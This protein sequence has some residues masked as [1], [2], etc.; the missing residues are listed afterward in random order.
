MKKSLIS[1]SGA[2]SLFFLSLFFVFGISDLKAEAN[3]YNYT[4]NF[5]NTAYKDSAGTTAI[6]N[7]T[8]GN[9]TLPTESKNQRMPSIDF[10]SDKELLVSWVGPMISGNVYAQKLDKNGNKIWANDVKV[11]PQSNEQHTVGEKPVIV[12]EPVA[13]KDQMNIFWQ[14]S[15]DHKLTFQTINSFGNVRLPVYGIQEMK[16]SSSSAVSSIDAA[17]FSNNAYTP[18]Y[19]VWVDNRNKN[20]GDIYL[21]KIK[22]G[23]SYPEYQWS[24]DVKVNS[25]QDGFQKSP[26]VAVDSKGDVYVVWSS[27]RKGGSVVSPTD[28]GIFMQK[29]SSSGV[30]LWSSD[31]VVSQ[32]GSSPSIDVDLSS[33]TPAVYVSWQDITSSSYNSRKYDVF[34]Q[35]FDLN[36]NIAWPNSYRIE[37]GL[38]SSPSPIV[39]VNQRSN[40]NGQPVHVAW[41]NASEKRIK[42]QGYRQDV[43]GEVICQYGSNC[44]GTSYG[45]I[46]SP[47]LSSGFKGEFDFLRG[48][49]ASR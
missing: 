37:S 47:I 44:V 30:R 16:L 33:D 13:Y 27:G 14:D 38:T 4:E 31:I 3:T 1:K 45:S 18:S 34:I 36:G 35:K 19:V 48:L 15:R 22:M 32:E 39:T 23:A 25:I 20:G 28:G 9:L 6:W 21:Q 29:F 40:C 26:K 24:S 41:Y 7:Y 11:G 8:S 10:S 42:I 49:P 2:L 46:S 5:T 12:R 17:H 43:T